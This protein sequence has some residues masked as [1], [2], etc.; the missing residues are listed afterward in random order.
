MKGQGKNQIAA[1]VA[2][3]EEAENVAPVNQ[4]KE[5]PEAGQAF[6]TQ[7]VYNLSD[8]QRGALEDMLQELKALRS[9]FPEE[10]VA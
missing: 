2:E 5:Q 8:R 7:K 6:P 3:A 9:L 4:A 1:Q 10:Q